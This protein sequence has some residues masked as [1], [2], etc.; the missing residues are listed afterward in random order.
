MVG[1]AVALVAESPHATFLGGGTNLVDLMRLGVEAPKLVVDV[2]RL[3]HDRVE[4][5]PEGGLRIGAAVRNSELSAHP[6]E[7]ADVGWFAEDALPERTA[8]PDQW[9]PHAFAAIRGEP[10]EVLYDEPRLPP[11]LGEHV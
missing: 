11:W 6:L 3:A 1:R 4:E 8:R 10:V 9:A 5:T 7:C 2:S